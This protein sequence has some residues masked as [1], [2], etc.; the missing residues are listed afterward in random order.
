MLVYFKIIAPIKKMIKNFR[1]FIS[2]SVSGSPKF[3][4]ILNENYVETDFINA[5][6][7]FMSLATRFTDWVPKILLNYYK[8]Y[9]FFD[10]KIVNVYNH[11]SITLW[12]DIP[13][14][15][16]INPFN[17]NSINNKINDISLWT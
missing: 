9:P 10:I 14:D 1:E 2:I 11:S 6:S 5:Q 15:N 7:H 4:H 13:V 16:Q 12:S 3:R 17:L 8:D